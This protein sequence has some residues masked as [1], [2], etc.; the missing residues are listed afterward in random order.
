MSGVLRRRAWSDELGAWGR[1]HGAISDEHG[2]LCITGTIIYQD[3]FKKSSS[4]L[5][6]DSPFLN[7]CSRSNKKMLSGN[8]CNYSLFL[9]V[10]G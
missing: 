9:K 2:V 3:G 5:Y 10:K 6:A 1:G 7:L 8:L 4:F